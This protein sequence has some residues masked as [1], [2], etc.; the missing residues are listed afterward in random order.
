MFQAN[1]FCLRKNLFKSKN[2][3]DICSAE[4]VNRLIVVTYHTEI[5]I[6]GCKNTYKFKLGRIGILILIHH[7]VTEPFL[8]RLQNLS[9][10]LK[11]FY[12]FYDQIVKIKGI[13][14]S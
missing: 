3:S 12:C 2:V 5:F 8:I 1:D 9:A 4:F 7:N 13:V 10:V 14:S 6:S 11:Q